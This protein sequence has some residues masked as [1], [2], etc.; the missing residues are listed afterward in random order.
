ML[1]RGTPNQQKPTNTATSRVPTLPRL[2]EAWQPLTRPIP[3]HRALTCPRTAKL[4]YS[5][6]AATRSA[7]TSPNPRNPA[8]V[9]ASIRSRRDKRLRSSPPRKAASPT[10]VQHVAHKPSSG[11]LSRHEL[12]GRSSRPG[13]EAGGAIAVIDEL[14]G[15]NGIVG[16]D[17]ERGS[18]TER[19][20]KCLEL[21]RVA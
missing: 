12:S 6:S 13:R 15:G 20:R 9:A 11:A 8:S 2:A 14:H 4:R 1:F 21:V 17:G 16:I 7:W 3:A 10:V 19:S 5:C 18:E